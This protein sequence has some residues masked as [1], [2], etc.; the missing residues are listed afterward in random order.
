[1]GSSV[2]RLDSSNSPE[3]LRRME[4]IE[5]DFAKEVERLEAEMGRKTQAE[6]LAELRDFVFVPPY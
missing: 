4:E 5:A 2:I 1:M 3:V 6:M